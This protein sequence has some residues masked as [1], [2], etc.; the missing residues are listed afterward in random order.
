MFILAL[1]GFLAGPAFSECIAPNIAG[2]TLGYTNKPPDPPNLNLRPTLPDCLRGLSQP[3]QENCTRDELGRY[4]REVDA[5]VAALNDYAIAT[6]RYANDTA[7]F[8]N[9]AVEYAR[10]ARE[11]AD[12]ALEFRN[13][14]ESEILSASQE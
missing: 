13:C 3:S 5:W 11:F 7:Q 1:S 12:L 9:S 10:R 6:H 4:G 2:L 8:A 14:E